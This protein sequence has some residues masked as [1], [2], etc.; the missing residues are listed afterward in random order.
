MFQ[1]FSVSIFVFILFIPRNKTLQKHKLKFRII[2]KLF[3]EESLFPE[4]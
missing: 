3:S 4:P 2:V 1:V